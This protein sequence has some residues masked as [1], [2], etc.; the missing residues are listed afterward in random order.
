MNLL[1]SPH[2]DD[3]TLFCSFTIQ[4]EQPLV[5]VVFDGRIQQKRGLPVTAQERRAETMAAMQE[6]GALTL[7]MGYSDIDDDP[8][9]LRDNIMNLILK[10]NPAKIW[11]PAV[12][13]G[14][15]VQHNLIGRIVK[16][17]FPATQRYLTYTRTG[18]KSINGKPVPIEPG[19][20][21]KKLR[22]LAHYTSQIDTVLNC[23]DHFLSDQ[24]EYMQS[25]A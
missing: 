17:L 13:E 3:E 2:N 15:H 19:M 21:Q 4:R 7:F 10:H 16:E 11:A 12:E 24:R 23:R 6:I 25:N 18:G 8:P 5:V 1:F 9:S 20:I 14:G 22:S